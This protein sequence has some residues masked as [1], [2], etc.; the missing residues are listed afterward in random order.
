MAASHR[1][2]SSPLAILLFVML[3]LL[4]GLA[5]T[6]ILAHNSDT[7]FADSSLV[8]RGTQCGI[9]RW[10]V[11]TLS[12]PDASYVELN[13]VPTTV[14]ELIGM[15]RPDPPPPDI[16]R[17]RIVPV[18]MTT[19]VTRALAI[20]FKPDSDN[21]TELLIADPDDINV[22][23]VADFVY[24]GCVGAV[25]SR[26]REEFKIA[27]AQ[28][29]SLFGDKASPSIAVGGRTLTIADWFETLRPIPNAGGVSPSLPS[30]EL[31]ESAL[32]EI[33]GIGFF[34]WRERPL[35]G[36]APN[37]IEL[38]PVLSIRRVP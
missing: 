7:S 6:W 14:R 2:L 16:D 32:V 12:D 1:H 9:D 27:F 18:E 15:K 10:A 4:S 31:T 19:Y 8:A 38:H 24:W 36:A 35:K 21:D 23:M 25:D 5:L 33:T 11:K 28:L 22:T 20:E 13:P 3:P 37:G 34:D 17:H 29:H 26:H 30:A